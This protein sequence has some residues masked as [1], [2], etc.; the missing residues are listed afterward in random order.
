MASAPF[1][2]CLGHLP[3]YGVQVGHVGLKI[4][5]FVSVCA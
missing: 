3:V 2:W 4:R 1:T 5:P